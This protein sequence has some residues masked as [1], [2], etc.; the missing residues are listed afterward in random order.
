[1]SE[2]LSSPSSPLVIPHWADRATGPN[3]RGPFYIVAS[4]YLSD[5]LW[6]Q[7]NAYK[8]K[9]ETGFYEEGWLHNYDNL[10]CQL[11]II[12]LIIFSTI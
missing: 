6:V 4:I 10:I 3:T 5:D 12:I 2:T 9:K 1:M 8:P 7:F 11:I